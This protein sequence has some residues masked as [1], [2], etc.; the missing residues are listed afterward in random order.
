MKVGLHLGRSISF[1]ADTVEE[2]FQFRRGQWSCRDNVLE[3]NNATSRLTLC[4]AV[5][6][7]HVA[8]GEEETDQS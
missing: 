3:E 8:T 6:D 4:K 7:P 1:V 5:N 2:G